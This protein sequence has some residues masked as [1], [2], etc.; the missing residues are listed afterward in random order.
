MNNTTTLQNKVCLVTGGTRGIGFAIARMLVSEGASV[1]ICGTNAEGVD[2]AVQALQAESP[3]KVKGKVADVSDYEKVRAL[4]DFVDRECGGLDVLVNNA[5]V[6]QFAKVQEATPELWESVLSTNL[7]GTFYCSREALL[8]FGKSAS[9]GPRGG[10][11][12]NISSLAGRNAFGAGAAYNASKFGVNG[13]SEALMLDA[14]Y[15]NVRVTVVAPGSVATQFGGPTGVPA[16][17]HEWK[18]WPEDVADIVRMALSMPRRAMVSY[19]E[20]RPSKPPRR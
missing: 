19:V 7:T 18:V 3:S 13:F 10:H 16:A 14:R 12:V 5:G 1:V 20:V 17:G 9:D 15:E 2:K 8:R 4:F 6:G 11:I